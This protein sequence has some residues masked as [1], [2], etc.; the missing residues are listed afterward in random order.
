[1]HRGR[2]TAAEAWWWR[3]R[4]RRK[5]MRAAVAAEEEE[6][7]G[8]WFSPDTPVSS[9]N[10]T[11]IFFSLLMFRKTNKTTINKNKTINSMVNL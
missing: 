1:M 5:R 9:I 3:R 4:R 8:R 6:A 11:D 2:R 7:A 10:K